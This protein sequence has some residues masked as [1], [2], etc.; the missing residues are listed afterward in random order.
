MRPSYR[1]GE[2]H[3]G[4]WTPYFR[5]PEKVDYQPVPGP[6]EPYYDGHY[7]PYSA[8]G[9]NHYDGT[10]RQR[11]YWHYPEWE[12]YYY[13]PN[14]KNNA[15]KYYEGDPDFRPAAYPPPPHA[16]R[17]A[18]RPFHPSDQFKHP[19]EYP[20]R[21]VPPPR[22]PPGTE[23]YDYNGGYPRLRPVYVMEHE[24]HWSTPKEKHCCGC[25]NHVCHSPQDAEYV[26]PAGKETDRKLLTNGN[27]EEDK[28]KMQLKE[29]PYPVVCFPSDWKNKFFDSKDYEGEKHP[30]NYNSRSFDDYP[31]R[32]FPG[33]WVPLDGKTREAPDPKQNTSDSKDVDKNSEDRKLQTLPFFWIPASCKSVKDEADGNVRVQKSDE[34]KK[35]TSE[36]DAKPTTPVQEVAK[37]IKARD[38]PVKQIEDEKPTHHIEES[39]GRVAVDQ[40]KAASSPRASKLPPVCLRV[41]PLPRKKS[42]NK[43]TSRSPSPPRSD[44]KIKVAEKPSTDAMKCEENEQKT[45]GEIEKVEFQSNTTGKEAEVKKTEERKAPKTQPSPDQAAVTIQSCY[46]GYQ[47][48][49]MQPLIKLRQIA[50]IKGRVDELKQQMAN[51]ELV[52]E[53]GRE[54][55]TKVR[56]NETLMGLLLQL[57]TIQGLH[58]MVRDVRKS[59]A[60]EL[61]EMQEK[62][63]ALAHQPI[64]NNT[65]QQAS[66]ETPS[67]KESQEANENV[68][69]EFN[70]TSPDSAH[71]SPN[72]EVLK[73]GQ[74]V[75]DENSFAQAAL[76]SSEKNEGMQLS[77]APEE[78]VIDGE[79]SDENL[80]ME[81]GAGKINTPRIDVGQEASEHENNES[82]SKAGK[83]ESQEL[84]HAYTEEAKGDAEM[85]SNAEPP[86]QT[87]SNAIAETI[88]NDM[89]EENSPEGREIQPSE[90]TRGE[91][92]ASV[93]IKVEGE[94]HSLAD[95]AVQSEEFVGKSQDALNPTAE[96]AI[97]GEDCVLNCNEASDAAVGELAIRGESAYFTE[98]EK[99]FGSSPKAEGNLCLAEASVEEGDLEAVEEKD[100]INSM[101]GAE[102]QAGEFAGKSD[103][104]MTHAVREEL[105]PEG[106]EMMSPAA[107]DIPHEGEELSDKFSETLSTPPSEPSNAETD[108]G[109]SDVV[110]KVVIASEIPTEAAQSIMEELKS[111][112]AEDGRQLQQ[113]DAKCETGDEDVVK[114]KGGEKENWEEEN[115]RLREMVEKLMEA[116][117]CQ[118]STIVE[119]N[120]K[121]KHLENKLSNTTK[122]KLGRRRS[123]AMKLKRNVN[124]RNNKNAA[125]SPK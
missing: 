48:R 25:P 95:V 76:E 28:T 89:Y 114:R 24:P 116:G 14:G 99:A 52:R 74:G 9:W 63:D 103:E 117:K 84:G 66:E 50:K 3:P 31:D 47:V 83:M 81:E 125:P 2:A 91:E 100:A 44:E 26:K 122:G 7:W 101:A 49:R 46:R 77:S 106:N 70:R 29:F 40:E 113:K 87:N 34:V 21:F 56:I 69:E 86:S 64:N 120:D 10:S 36:G 5:P 27:N 93:A 79:I 17:F 18:Y 41:D 119:L 68:R 111:G 88:A 12:E 67:V 105:A 102:V 78:A 71:L 42:G 39:G 55:K 65:F 85:E 123:G 94:Y 118:M 96:L 75:R 32:R 82:V 22:Y 51:P 11:D 30:V 108:S 62:L 61:V 109:A 72:T 59:V 20:M 73:D 80:S 98:E 43:S 37:E 60:R 115:E 57:D 121:I 110:D 107:G 90:G 6:R 33:Y 53:L 19:D 97:E 54:A 35:Q 104:E 38:I 16:S 4:F 1:Y 45:C 112:D 92:N 15:P 8:N 13:S 58:P 124:L 23:R